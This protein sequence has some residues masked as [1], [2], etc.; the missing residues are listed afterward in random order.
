MRV[1]ASIGLSEGRSAVGRQIHSTRVPVASVVAAAVLALGACATHEETGAV[2]GGVAGAVLGSKV[3]S[4][5]GRHIAIAIGAIAGTMIGAS[6]GRHMDEQDRHL[7]G[8]GLEN[9][10]TGEPSRWRNPDTG[11]DYTLTPT[12]TFDDGRIPCREFTMEAR[13]DGR[14]ELV[15]GTACRETDGRWIVTK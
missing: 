8:L 7:A 1:E 10:R 3:G 2:V 11:I 15:H 6:I 13:I 9:N 12:R 4:G 14:P 5:E